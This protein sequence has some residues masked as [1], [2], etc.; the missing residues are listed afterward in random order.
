MS[1]MVKKSGCD[2]VVSRLSLVYIFHIPQS[3]GLSLFFLGTKYVSCGPWG[4]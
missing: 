4:S 1:A 3:M 2:K